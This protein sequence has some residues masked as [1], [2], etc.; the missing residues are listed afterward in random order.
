MKRAL[1]CTD[2]RMLFSGGIGTYEQNL[3][4]R[5]DFSELGLPVRIYYRTDREAD[6]LRQYQPKA[7]LV[8]CPYWIYRP[9]E[10]LFWLRNLKGGFFWAPSYNIPWC[11]YEKLVATLHDA[12]LCMTR[13]VSPILNIYSRVMFGRIAQKAD[14]AIAVSDFAKKMSQERGGLKK[15]PI[16][17]TKLGVESAWSEDEKLPKPF[18][19]AYFVYVGNI[20]PHKNLPRFL[21]AFKKA[22]V[23]QKLV[24]VGAFKNLKLRD[25]KAVRAMRAMGERVVFADELI[26]APLRA[27]VKG[28]DGLVMPSVYEGF[29]LPPLEAMAAGVPALVSTAEPMPELCGESPL[30]FDPLDIGQMTEGLRCLAGLQGDERTRRIEQGRKRAAEYTWEKTARE[31]M[32]VLRK[33]LAA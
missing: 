19:F 10:Q 15:L 29:G 28:S 3:F 4:K 7:E 1:F 17:V 24:C 13:Y 23:P 27:V 18:D 26:G 16:Y 6:F 30:Y 2:A 33:V 8:R 25:E 31:T 32:D 21:E 22:D 20:K 12:C 11:G 5:M 14:A 9:Q